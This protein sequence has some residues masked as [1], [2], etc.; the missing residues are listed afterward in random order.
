MVIIV[1]TSFLEDVWMGFCEDRVWQCF[2]GIIVVMN[3][4]KRKRR[5]CLH[6]GAS[7]MKFGLHLMKLILADIVTAILPV[8]TRRKKHCFFLSFFVGELVKQ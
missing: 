3:W 1:R 7:S 2:G 6:C 4:P 8:M 5:I